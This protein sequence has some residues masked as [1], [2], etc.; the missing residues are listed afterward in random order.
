MVSGFLFF[1]AR[2]NLMVATTTVEAQIVSLLVIFNL[3]FY[4]VGGGYLKVSAELLA[5]LVILTL[6]A[7]IKLHRII[8]SGGIRACLELFKAA[9]SSTEGWAYAGITSSCF[10]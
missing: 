5:V 3:F 8:I 10:Y 6:I 7:R 1:R 4:G 9:G 2:L